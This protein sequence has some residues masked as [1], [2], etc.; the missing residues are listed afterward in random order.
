MLRRVCSER[1]TKR[2]AGA[3]V[4]ECRRGSPFAS[5]TR[6]NNAVGSLNPLKGGGVVV[7]AKRGHTLDTATGARPV[8]PRP[9]QAVAIFSHAM[10]RCPAISKSL[11]CLC[12]ASALCL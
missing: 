9:H 12:L 2:G 4:V 11:W 5:A 7:L 1:W 10:L 3:L 6:V 8:A